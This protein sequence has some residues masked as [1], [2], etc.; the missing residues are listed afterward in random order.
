MKVELDIKFKRG[1]LVGYKD[2]VAKFVY[3]C[4][5]EHKGARARMYCPKDDA[6]FYGN[7]KYL[8]KLDNP[9]EPW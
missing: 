6:Y 8:K 9:K 2:G 5:I 1:E 3:M 7:P 4:Y